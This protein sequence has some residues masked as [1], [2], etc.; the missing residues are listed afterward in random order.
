M[1]IEAETVRLLAAASL[2]AAGSAMPA[3]AGTILDAFEVASE[4]D[5]NTAY[6]K[7]MVLAKAGRLPEA[8]ETL[9]GVVSASPSNLEA[10]FALALVYHADGKVEARDR[11][12]QEIIDSGAATDERVAAAQ[13]L[14]NAKPIAVR[15]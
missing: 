15:A 12:A 14:L 5:E 1:Q 8:I 4:R 13:D 2:V 11:I 6:V 9:D 10:K 3:E 7:G